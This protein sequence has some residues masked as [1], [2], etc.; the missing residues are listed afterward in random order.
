MR[1]RQRG[2]E[3]EQREKSAKN[4]QR[5]LITKGAAAAVEHSYPCRAWER[6]RELLVEARPPAV[7][8]RAS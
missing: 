1:E 4:K 6:E 2:S 5:A 7:L 3:G 8:Y